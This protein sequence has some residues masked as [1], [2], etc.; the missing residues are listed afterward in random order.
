[1]AADEEE[2]APAKIK[3]FTPQLTEKKLIRIDNSW[4]ASDE[5]NGTRL[6]EEVDPKEVFKEG[7]SKTVTV[8]QYERSVVG[9]GKMLSPSWL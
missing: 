4:Y 7:A 5:T 1:M 2:G 6:P 8:N 3:G 9:K